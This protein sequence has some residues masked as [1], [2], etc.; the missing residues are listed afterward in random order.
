MEKTQSGGRQLRHEH[1]RRIEDYPEADD[2]SPQ[3]EVDAQHR[4]I[5][6]PGGEDAFELSVTELLIQLW[7]FTYS[8]LSEFPNIDAVAPW[9][10][11]EEKIVGFPFRYDASDALPDNGK[12]VALIA[13]GVCAEQFEI[14]PEGPVEYDPQLTGQLWTPRFSR[15]VRHV[16]QIQIFRSLSIIAVF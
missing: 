2:G 1:G 11:L 8:R 12:T 6:H 13:F 15:S 14:D 7:N 3:P 5:E 10:T 4:H 9:D 16:A